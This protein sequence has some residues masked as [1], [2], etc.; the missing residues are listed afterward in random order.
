[1][2]SNYYE[3]L[4]SIL[5]E[6]RG[7]HFFPKESSWHEYVATFFGSVKIMDGSSINIIIAFDKHFPLRLP[8]FYV[9]NDNVFRVHVESDGKI[10]LYD[11]SSMLIKKEMP[12]QLLLDCY[13]Q[14][15]KILNILPG[16][17]EYNHEIFREFDA[18]W[19]K[20]GSSRWVYSC[21]DT[22]EVT[23]NEYN[24]FF[25]SNI[26]V[27][28]KTENDALVMAYN[29]LNA[30]R[31]ESDFYKK[32]LVIRLRKKTSLI[33]IRENYKWKALR[34]YILSN[35]SASYKKRF[36]KFLQKKI[37]KIV[38]YIFLV[39][40]T[41]MGDIVF[42]FRVD[43]SGKKY[44]QI[45]NVVNAKIEPVYVKRIDYNYLLA[46]VNSKT[47]LRDKKILLLGAGSIGGFLANNLCQ[48]GVTQLDILDMDSFHEENVCRHFL[49]FDSAVNRTVTNK[50]DLL[51]EQLEKMYPYVDIDSLNYKERSVEEFIVQYKRFENYDVIISALGEPTLNLEINRILYQERIL[52]PFVCCFNEP[53]GIGGHVIVANL[54]KN[55]C[56]Q[57]LYT[58]INA[59]EITSFRASLVEEG[60]A[61]KKNVSGC[62]GAFVPYSS[63]DS[64]QTAI[65][66][67]RLVVKVLRGEIIENTIETWIGPCNELMS[68]HF[69]V[70]EYYN[71]LCKN[72]EYVRT[73]F[74]NAHCAI[75]GGDE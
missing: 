34:N 2:D 32:C 30:K 44:M 54:D 72:K 52:T 70:S 47:S 23:Y 62:S 73:K 14:A 64:Q 11:K 42:G 25:S 67:A 12:D 37:K 21:F 5:N 71:I 55:S 43:I 40:E 36:E 68:N 4:V 7:V 39:Y 49:G 65:L 9:N 29:N 28:A 22:S 24:M 56:L 45:S 75:C 6:Q 35:I 57:C 48:M 69:R 10:C 66:A 19:M 15:I 27:V 13:D 38:Q 17:D 3:K 33:S 26:R 74:G 58:K 16:T 60:Q 53:Y 20:I 18:Y 8:V 31:K 59:S 1:M 50:A 51:K 63:L 46:R 41:P 61:F